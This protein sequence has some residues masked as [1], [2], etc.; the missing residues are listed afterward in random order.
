VIY[1]TR[2]EWAA[3]LLM[4]VALHAG[5]DVTSLVG[6]QQKNSGR[7]QRGQAAASACCVSQGAD[8][9]WLERAGALPAG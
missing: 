7:P 1:L 6:P 2:R 5:T 3:Q 9:A 8:G 4:Q